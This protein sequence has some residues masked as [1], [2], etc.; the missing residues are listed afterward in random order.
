MCFPIYD[1]TAD[2][3]RLPIITKIFYRQTPAF[4]ILS[5]PTAIYISSYIIPGSNSLSFLLPQRKSDSVIHE[6][7]KN[8]A[9]KYPAKSASFENKSCICVNCHRQLSMKIFCN[10]IRL[11]VGIHMDEYFLAVLLD[12]DVV[13]HIPDHH[14]GNRQGSE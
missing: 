11:N 4:L 9:G 2:S 6:A 3:I 12:L 10:Q 1:M 7:V 13:E 14:Q 5:L 8:S